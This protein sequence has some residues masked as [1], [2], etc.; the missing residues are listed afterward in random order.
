M[1]NNVKSRNEGE[2][3]P[4]LPVLIF[5][6]GLCVVL[7][8]AMAGSID[9]EL[10]SPQAVA[11]FPSQTSSATTPSFAEPHAAEASAIY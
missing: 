5:G 4:W 3:I 1:H 8:C 10:R 2:E 7:A 11:G 9:P 6:S